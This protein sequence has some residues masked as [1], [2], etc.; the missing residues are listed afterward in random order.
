MRTLFARG[1]VEASVDF[2]TTKAKTLIFIILIILRD[3]GC[4]LLDGLVCVGD[5]RKGRNF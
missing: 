4:F 1:P 2:V 5:S 3:L